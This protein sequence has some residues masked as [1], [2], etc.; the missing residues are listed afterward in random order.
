MYVLGDRSDTK[1]LTMSS[2][3]FWP[4]PGDR[5]GNHILG[6]DWDW[7]YHPLASRSSN[8]RPSR[9]LDRQP[10]SATD[11]DLFPPSSAGRTTINT[12]RRSQ[13]TGSA[14]AGAAPSSRPDAAEIIAAVSFKPGTEEHRAGV[15]FATRL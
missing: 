12:L 10:S 15:V 13:N 1:L 9:T 11:N 7:H 6:D 4:Q 14:Y 5:S 3:D 2:G 8:D